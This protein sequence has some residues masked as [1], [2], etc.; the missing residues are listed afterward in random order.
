MLS[1]VRTKRNN[2]C[3]L[4]LNGE[5]VKFMEIKIRVNPNKKKSCIKEVK[6][7]VYYVDIKGRA[8]K[9][10]ANKEVIRFFSKK[11]KKNVRILKGLKNRNK[12]LILG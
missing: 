5:L 4:L 10:E 1:H 11:F 6:D 3:G 2:L 8:E 12:S 9:G 7:G